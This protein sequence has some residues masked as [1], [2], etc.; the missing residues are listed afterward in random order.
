MSGVSVTNFTYA[1][2][3]TNKSEIE[4]AA[5]TVHEHHPNESVW[6]QYS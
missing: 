1:I 2:D 4:D 3:V 6:V 5:Y